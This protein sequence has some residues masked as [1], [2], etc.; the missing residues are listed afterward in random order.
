MNVVELEVDPTFAGVMNDDF[1][2]YIPF[3]MPEHSASLEK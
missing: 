3:T 2:C 1:G